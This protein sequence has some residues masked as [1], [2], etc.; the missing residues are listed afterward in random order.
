MQVSAAIDQI[1]AYSDNVAP[2]GADEADR[3]QRILYWLIEEASQTY[4]A[5][6]WSYRLK[7]SV[8]PH[9]LVPESQGYGLLPSDFLMIGKFGAVYNDSQ[10]GAPMDPAAESEIADFIAMATQLSNPGKFAIFGTEAQTPPA[11]PLQRIWIGIN[12]TA[13]TLRLFY[14]PQ[15]PT[16]N[17]S[18]GNNNLDIAIPPQYQQTV[19][20]PGV[21]AKAR[22]SKGDNR[23]QQD[24]DERNAGLKEMIRNN[25]RFQ[26]GEQRLPSFFGY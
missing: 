6:E 5:R 2:V 16:L 19:I 12:P 18:A 10:N 26:G 7:P 22:R 25:R 24:R 14:H 4:Y 17:E 15:M 13:V 11:A 8:A 1:L 21:R 23:W 20:I 9:V 3:R